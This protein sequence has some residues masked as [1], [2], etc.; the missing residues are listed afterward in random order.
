MWDKKGGRMTQFDF[1]E[2]IIYN[3]VVG[4]SQQGDNECT[5]K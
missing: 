1:I 2:K 4:T 5:K 3:N